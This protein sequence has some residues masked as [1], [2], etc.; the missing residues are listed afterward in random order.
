VLLTGRIDR[1]DEGPGGT[2]LVD[3]KTAEV[4]D[5]E[6]ADQRAKEDLQLS[7]YA[8]AWRE[9]TGRAPDR[10][11][12]RYVTAGTS[13]GAAMTESRIERTREKVAA[14]AAAIRAGEFTARPTEYACRR[15]PCRPICRESAV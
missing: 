12:L 3:Y 1:V 7:V 15:C 5:D 9:I 6:R 8:L 4:D 13:G 2:V 14:V 10:V 11:E